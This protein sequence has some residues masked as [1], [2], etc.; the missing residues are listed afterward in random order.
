MSVRGLLTQSFDHQETRSPGDSLTK[1]FAYQEGSFTSSKVPAANRSCYSYSPN[2]SYSYGHSYSYGPLPHSS[3]YSL[4]SLYSLASSAWPLQSSIRDRLHAG[5]T[6]PQPEPL[7][8]PGPHPRPPQPG[9]SGS[10]ATA[11]ATATARPSYSPS[12]SSRYGEPSTTLRPLQPG[13]YSLA[14]T[15]KPL[16]QG[17]KR[18]HSLAS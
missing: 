1:R 5:Q 10:P 15:T 17:L 4:Y 18:S 7:T 14:F 2:P 3:I 13:L 11:T 6:L 12:Y 16:Q 8:R 9:L